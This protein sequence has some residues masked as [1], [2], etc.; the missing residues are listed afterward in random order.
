MENRLRQ[1]ESVLGRVRDVSE[2]PLM[3]SESSIA[4]DN[5]PKDLEEQGSHAAPSRHSVSNHVANDIYGSEQTEASIN[6]MGVLAFADEQVS[7]FFGK[8]SEYKKYELELN[9]Y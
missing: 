6:T 4:G 7:G 9:L 3:I 2:V 1:F 5:C 8:H